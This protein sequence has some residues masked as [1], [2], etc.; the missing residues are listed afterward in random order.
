MNSV[1]VTDA[2]E[3][4]ELGL[5]KDAAAGDGAAFAALYDAY[6]KRIYNYCLRILTDGHDAEDATQE[7]FLRVLKRLPEMEGKDVAFGP[8]LFTTARN[9]TYDMIGNRKTAQPVADIPEAGEGHL[10]RDDIDLEIDPERAAMAGSQRLSV[11]AANERLPARQRE[12][13][14]L[15]E[16]EEMSYEDIAGAMDLNSN[17]V[18][19]LISRART[20]LRSEMRIGSAAAVAPASADCEKAL[21]LLAMRQ[22]GESSPTGEGA[23]LGTHLAGCA[24]CRLADEEMAEAG[25]SYR[26]WTPAIPAAYLFRDTLAKASEAVGADWSAVERPA[27]GSGTGLSRRAVAGAVTG[28]VLLAVLVLAILAGRVSDSSLDPEPAGVAI[29][30][31]LES[32]VVKKDG[33]KEKKKA[34]TGG[35]QGKQARQATDPPGGSAVPVYEAGS[36]SPRAGGKNQKERPKAPDSAGGIGA[37]PG[38]K[39]QP[40]PQPEPE[41]QPQPQPQPEPEP[42]PDP[43]P[44]APVDPPVVTPPRDPVTPPPSRPKVP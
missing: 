7:A 41:P 27:G 14:V 25:I 5:A 32:E 1:Q 2:S 40:Q 17:A 18:A 44:P 6:E 35:K 3:A 43:E 36:E 23:W 8:Y 12:V 10:H 33:G 42:Q 26:A 30:A 4:E 15:R 9:V 13:L 22:D 37:D 31:T 19:Q 29:P 38:P 24:T 34:R 16:V 20:R 21:P 28:A 11:Q 39:P